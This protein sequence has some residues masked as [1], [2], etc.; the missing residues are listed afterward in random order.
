[1]SSGSDHTILDEEGDYD[2][3]YEQE[4]Y[5]AEVE[6]ALYGM[7]RAVGLDTYQ[8][9]HQVSSTHDNMAGSLFVN[10][11]A[12]GTPNNTHTHTHRSTRPGSMH[13]HARTH[14]QRERH[15]HTHN[16]HTLK[17]P[18][19]LQ[20]DLAP[21]THTH[22]RTQHTT[23]TQHTHAHCTHTGGDTGLTEKMFLS[24]LRTKQIMPALVSEDQARNAFYE[25]S[26]SLSVS[27][28][29]PPCLY[30]PSNPRTRLTLIIRQVVERRHGQ[31]GLKGGEALLALADFKSL[32]R[33]FLPPEGTM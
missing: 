24:L 2:S 29:V 12:T 20:L 9:D 32:V 25:V 5:P 4:R 33:S 6:Q 18:A 13:T 27:S 15:T 1:M 10:L 22:A 28:S 11:P 19:W 16:T 31:K 3:A 7:P 8:N 14:T 21:H 26:V 23:H 17:G 30:F